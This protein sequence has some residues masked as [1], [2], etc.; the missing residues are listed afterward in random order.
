MAK[1]VIVCCDGTWNDPDDKTHIHW[2]SE[3]CQREDADPLQQVVGYFA[4]VGTMPVEILGGGAFGLGLS[5]NIRTAYRFVRDNWR[6]GDELYIFGFSRGAYTARSLGGFIERV[7]WLD[8]D[9]WVDAAYLWYRLSRSGSDGTEPPLLAQILGPLIRT[10]TAEPIGVTFLGVFDTVGA[11]G[12]PFQSADVAAD[13]GVDRIL[14]RVGL[15]ALGRVVG[16]IEDRVRRPIEG[17]HDTELGAHVKNAYHALAVDERRGPFLPTLWT[18][19][20]ATSTVEQAWFAG[21]HGDVGGNYHD[22]PDDE[23]LALIP[24]LW[25]MEKAVAL[26][27][28]LRPGALEAPRDAADPLA[29]QHD[30]LDELWKFAIAL[31]PIEAID[32]PIGNAARR[33]RDPSGQKFPLVEANETIH[34]SVRRRLGQQ[35][36]VRGEHSRAR[37]TYRPAGLPAA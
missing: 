31:G 34:P 9:E 24:L 36:E 27:L 1:R 8:Q 2:I 14:D 4:G 37:I 15:S 11:L 26:G 17:F 21:V 29:A 33:E 30:S 7:G 20:P 6:P 32:R 25:M 3:H 22:A 13:L 10:H 16:A 5:R 28:D 12:I 18:K 19:V 23:R 35:V